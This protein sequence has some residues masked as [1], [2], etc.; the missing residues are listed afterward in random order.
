MTK[1]VNPV[2]KLDRLSEK[3]RRDFSLKD[4]AREKCLKASREIIR[5]SSNSIRATHRREKGDA[6]K[7]LMAASSLIIELQNDFKIKY[8]ELLQAN[9]VHDAYKEFAEASITFDIIFNHDIPYPDELNV[10]Y[11]SYL[12]GLAES[13]GELRRFLLDS[14]RHDNYQ[15]SER[16]LN[17]M[18]QIYNVLV[19]IDFPDAIT[20]GLRRNTDNV[21]GILEKTRGDLTLI[22]QNDILRQ[23]IDRL[24]KK[25]RN[26]T[27]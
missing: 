11:A 1:Q 24:N 23:R 15:D 2:K 5:Y 12:N 6:C 7:L 8:R 13:V 19:T 20:Y 16:L 27:E 4:S 10:T 26:S 9:Y 22:Q 14:L 21:R 18:D 25:L 3:I 17:I